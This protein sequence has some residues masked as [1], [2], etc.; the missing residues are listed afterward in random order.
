MVTPLPS[1]FSSSSPPPSSSKWTLTGFLSESVTPEFVII[2]CHLILVLFLP[3]LQFVQLSLVIK[4][5]V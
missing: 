5:G 4:I 3:S 2:V 1:Y